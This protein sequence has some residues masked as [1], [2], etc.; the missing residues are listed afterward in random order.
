MGCLLNP[1]KFKCFCYTQKCKIIKLNS[2]SVNVIQFL[3]PIR[4]NGRLGNYTEWKKKKPQWECI[5]LERLPWTWVYK[6]LLKFMLSEYCFWFW[7][8]FFRDLFSIW[9]LEI[10]S[11]ISAIFWTKV[12]P[13]VSILCFIIFLLMFLVQNLL[14]FL[15]QNNSLKITVTDSSTGYLR[16]KDKCNYIVTL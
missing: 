2:D 14:I 7:F 1:I 15:I 16:I 10:P 11:S 3:F 6:Y 8:L 13:M 5:F 12:D 4:E 9:L